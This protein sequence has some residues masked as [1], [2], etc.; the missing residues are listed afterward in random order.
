MK[1]NGIILNQAV[2]I[3]G[4]NKKEHETI[5]N[6]DKKDSIEISPAGKSLSSYSPENKFINSKEKIEDIKKAVE[7]GTYNVDK[8]LV[9]AKIL[10]AMK[11]KIL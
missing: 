2:N 6:V 10:D 7:N 3:Y 9:A 5:K 8:K 11:G 4:G 1:I